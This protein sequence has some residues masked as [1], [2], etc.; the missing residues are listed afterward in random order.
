MVK[1]MRITK[2][3]VVIAAAV[4]TSVGGFAPAAIAAPN[5]EKPVIGPGSPLRMPF[6]SNPEVEGRHVGNPMCS[7][8]V[9]GTVV[10]AEGKSHRVIM[11]AGHCLKAED[12]KTKEKLSGKYFI[13]TKHGDVLVGQDGLATDVMPSEEDIQNTKS[14]GEFFNTLFN[15][16]DYGFI[17]VNDNV[18]TTSISHSVDEFGE[19][20]GEPVQI[21]GIQD[22]RTLAPMEISFDNAGQPVCTD[23]SR[24]GRSCGFQMFRVR[25]GVWAIA[26]IDHGDSGG[27]AYNPETREAIGIN[28]MGLGPI[29]RFQPA[30][31]ALEE[32]YG[33]PDGQVNE[34]FKVAQ[35]NAPQSEFRTIDEDSKFSEQHKP[36]EGSKLGP[37]ADVL[38]EGVEIPDEVGNLIPDL[39]SPQLPG[40][41]AEAPSSPSLPG[42]DSVIGQ[43]GIPNLF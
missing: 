12:E 15:S 4:A 2:K 18:E 32:A 24:S 31:V 11:T 28:S 29:S 16:G 30:D 7:L 27:N 33:I 8:A 9:P 37:I 26:P 20:H 13:P 21:V 36:K 5:V 40:A 23:G 1:D 41:G 34:R 3:S 6:P 25:N 17:E 38:P 42:L 10:D 43:A 22:N 39:P 19:V 35:S 14:A